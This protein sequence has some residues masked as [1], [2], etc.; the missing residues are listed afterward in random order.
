MKRSEKELPNTLIEN[1]LKHWIVYYL[2]N[3]LHF[4]SREKFST[5]EEVEKYISD[6]DNSDIH[7]TYLIKNIATNHQV[8]YDSEEGFVDFE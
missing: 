4:S 1:A 5:L 3:G 2:F 6:H 7:Y 8:V